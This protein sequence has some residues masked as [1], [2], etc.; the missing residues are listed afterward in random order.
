M[1]CCFEEKPKNFK[2]LFSCG[3]FFSHG[4]ARKTRMDRFSC[5]AFP[6]SLMTLVESSSVMLTSPLSA[7][8]HAV[9]E[10][11]V[12]IWNNLGMLSLRWRIIITRKFRAS[13]VNG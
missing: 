2:S 12:R 9:R 10:L 8:L 3:T 11:P 4:R 1:E 13:L 6:E 5:A 7:A